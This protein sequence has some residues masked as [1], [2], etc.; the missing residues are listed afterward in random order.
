MHELNWKWDAL[1]ALRVVGAAILGGIV[2]WQREH[3]GRAA[4]VRT[5]AAVSLGSC[6]FALMSVAAGPSEDGRIA[7]QV[8]TGVGFLCAG[9]IIREQGRIIGLTTAATLWAT[10]AIGLSVAFQRFLLAVLVTILLFTLLAA[11]KRWEH[12]QG[13]VSAGAPDDRTLPPAS[14]E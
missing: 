6:L 11:P 4:G 9:V 5:Y 2:G 3:V 8:V 10:A 13:G 1:C 12:H 14:K 7:A